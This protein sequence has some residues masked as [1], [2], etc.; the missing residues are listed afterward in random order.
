VAG[1]NIT[2]S[3]GSLQLPA[4]LANATITPLDIAKT[5]DINHQVV[6]NI[7]I[8]LQS[9]DEDGNPSN[10]ISISA[11]AATAATA[12]VNFDV[13]TS[14][15]SA[16]AA[17][18]KL[19][20]NSGSVN[21]TLVSEAT[22]KAHFQNTL[23]G[24]TGTT[25]INV[26]PMAHAGVVQNVVAGSGVMLNGSAS[27]DANGDALTYTWTLTSKP[28]GSAAVLAALT[29]AKP[30]FTADVAGTYVISLI[31][32]DGKL[33]SAA[34]TITVTAAVANVAP[35]ANAGIAQSV[36]AGSVVTLDG[37]ASS[38]ANGD[39][40]TY[41][42]TLTSK[43]AGSAAALATFTLA[44]PLFTADLAG[45][46]VATLIVNDGKLSSTTSTVFIAASVANAIPVANA[47]M[48]QKVAPGV[49]VALDGSAS[50]DANADPLTYLWVLTSKPAGSV[51]ALS[52]LT[53]VKPTFTADLAGTY[54]AGLTVN[55]GKVN[56]NV[57]TIAITAAANTLTLL[58]PADSFFGGPDIVLPMPYATVSSASAN[59]ACV[60]SNCA[61]VYDVATY[62]LSAAGQSYT[63]SNLQAINLT[64]GSAITPRFS[65]LVNGQIIANGTTATFKLQSPF[66]LGATVN[67][68][69]SFTVL[70]TGN[71]FSHTV[72]LRTN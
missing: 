60:G 30:T 49:T 2:F 6:S 19:V 69:Y 41:A 52:S 57:S 68:K 63:I 17:V 21:K 66:T 72:Q 54:V 65:G 50:S 29:S 62:R 3:I 10:G 24:T 25:K 34:S 47:G 39:T 55:D 16:N 7:L 40:L 53:T 56:S 20:A 26:A 51:A 27:V 9:L 36:I 46:Y 37:S 58:Q 67:L 18:T 28:T 14:A 45:T 44:K 13:S 33:N 12:G 48:A 38:D 22:A 8:L 4:V 70:E 1:E 32:N 11:A 61:S 59:V 5:T 42:W 31:V 35:M 64:N 43:P 23:N 71:N 15:F